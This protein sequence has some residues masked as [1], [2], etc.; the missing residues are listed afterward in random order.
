MNL[1]KMAQ[2]YSILVIFKYIGGRGRAVAWTPSR[3]LMHHSI[4]LV[5]LNALLFKI[6]VINPH[7]YY[8]FVTIFEEIYLTGCLIS[9][10]PKFVKCGLP[11]YLLDRGLKVLI[12]KC[13]QTNIPCYQVLEIQLST[14]IRRISR[15]I[16]ILRMTVWR[17]LK[18]KSLHPYHYR[19]VC[20]SVLEAEFHYR[21]I[22]ST[23]ILGQTDR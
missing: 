3:A 20:T 8:F 1:H 23:S 18:H 4:C 10:S 16:E 2:N 19:K 11:G 15:Q 13:R 9:V 12:C 22:Y 7:K 17:L 6:I 14:N 5:P 21:Q